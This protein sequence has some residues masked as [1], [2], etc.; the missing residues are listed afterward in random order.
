MEA[1]AASPSLTFALALGAG[2]TCQLVARHIRVPS[3]V[4]L[5]GAGV[6]LGPDLLGWIDPDD[7][8]QGLF[9]LVSLAVAIILFEGGLNLDIKRLRRE[10]AVIQRLVTWGALITAALGGIAAH[11]L[12]GWPVGI[13][14]LF[15]SLV[16][17][18]GPTVI[19]PLL[20][21]VPLR[22]RLATVL[23]SEGL[24]IDPVGALLAAVVLEVVLTPAMDTAA[25]ELLGLVQRAGLG[26]FA[27]TAA[28]LAM[29]GLL[30]F[31]RAVPEGLE[32]LLALGGALVTFALCEAILSES[33]ILAVTIA[34]VVVGNLESRMARELGEFQETLTVGLIGILFVLLAADVRIEDVVGLGIPGIAT[35][36][37]LALVVRPINVALCAAGSELAPRER[38]FLAWVGPRGVVAAAIAALSTALL[39]E[40]GFEQASQIQALVFL[41]IATTVVIQGG[42][43]PLVARLLGVRAP[44]RDLWVILGAEELGFALAE[45]LSDDP[46][47]VL[48]VDSNPKH[49][50]AA[51]ERGHGVVYGDAL[52]PRTL[53]RMRLE[54]ARGVIA[55]T[56]NDDVNHHFAGE[57][58]DEYDVRDTWVGVGR[59][60]SGVTEKIIEKQSSHVLFDGPKDVERWHVRLRHDLAV[61][62]PFQVVDAAEVDLDASAPR[63]ND[64]DPYLVLARRDPDGN[65]NTWIPMSRGAKLAEGDEVLI[66][67]HEP[68][69]EAAVSALA[70]VGLAPAP[71]DGDAP[72]GTPEA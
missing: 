4:L 12:M 61:V 14:V 27:G 45:K 30:R 3:I 22:P 38:A 6:A 64:P 67:L 58:R 70:G 42:T 26:L 36:A 41:T 34:G 51:E 17:V 60:R 40:H 7:L 15:G 20:R 63:G 62:R 53:A 59:Q 48:F 66:V 29:V 68:E 57:A 35:V 37:V 43:A 44:G 24:L 50:R 47:G 28:G 8:G 33:G 46:K 72:R 52:E 1:E 21:N 18:T 39:R 56:P 11:F 65:G 10:A 23:E 5:L 2:V 32:N 54:R 49:C 69:A 13:S 55:L 25:A 31:R 71:T 9:A 16:V 19:R